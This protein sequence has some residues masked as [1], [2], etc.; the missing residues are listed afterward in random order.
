MFLLLSCFR[1]AKRLERGGK[2]HRAAAGHDFDVL[3]AD[4]PEG[5]MLS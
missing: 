5:A 2:R 1:L 3:D 4:V